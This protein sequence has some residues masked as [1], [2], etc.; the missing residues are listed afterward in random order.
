MKLGV[1]VM[2]GRHGDVLP[3]PRSDQVRPRSRSPMVLLAVM[4]AEGVAFA[5][6]V[7]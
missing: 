6:L 4:A 3:Q 1:V 5:V 2:A 7:A